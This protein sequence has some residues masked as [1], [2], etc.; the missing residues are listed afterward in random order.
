MKTLRRSVFAV[1]L[2]ASLVGVQPAATAAVTT[3]SASPPVHSVTG[4][5]FLFIGGRWICFP[6]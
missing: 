3:L 4:C 1:A 2:L 5:C 6:C